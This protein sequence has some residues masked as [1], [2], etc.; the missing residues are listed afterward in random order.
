MFRQSH[1]PA[2]TRS[3]QI[4]A[5]MRELHVADRHLPV[6]TMIMSLIAAANAASV[7]AMLIHL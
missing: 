1:S 3:A 5:E 7:V 2:Q 4:R 6:A